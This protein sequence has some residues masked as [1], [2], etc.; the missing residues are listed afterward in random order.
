MSLCPGGTD[1]LVVHYAKMEPTPP[2]CGVGGC[3]CTFKARRMGPNCPTF[4]AG[5]GEID[6]AIRTPRSVWVPCNLDDHS[7]SV[8]P[9]QLWLTSLFYAIVF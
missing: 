4:D 2:A 3:T 6:P 9:W 1:A 7:W 8:F 5:V